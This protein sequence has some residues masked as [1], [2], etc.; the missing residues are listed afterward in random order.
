VLKEQYGTKDIGLLFVFF[1]NIFQLK[2]DQAVVI[3]PNVPHAY[4]HGE[5][6]ECMANSDNVVRCGLTPKF[7]DT[8][9][10][11]QMLPY[12]LTERSPIEGIKLVS[13]EKV[14]VLEYKTGYSE[15]RVFKVEI[16]GEGASTSFRYNC[17]TMAVVIGGLGEVEVE[18]MGMFYLDTYCAYYLLPEREFRIISS[19]SEPLTVYLANCDI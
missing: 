9:T 10:L 17:F 19:G 11:Y 2:K 7:K 6:I 14:G 5:I 15:F 13:N 12:D 8:E 3:T 18:G 16:K 4:I 1:F